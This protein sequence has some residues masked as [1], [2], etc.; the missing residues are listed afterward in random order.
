MLGATQTVNMITSSKQNYGRVEVAVLNVDL[1]PNMIDTVVIGD[2][3]FSLPIH[4]EGRVENE[5]LE[6]QM[7]LDEGAGD[8]ANGFDKP[9]NSGDKSP[10]GTQKLDKPEGSGSKKDTSSRGKQGNGSSK[11]RSSAPIDSDAVDVNVFTP[12][13]HVKLKPGNSSLN[14]NQDISVQVTSNQE[15]FFC[16]GNIFGYKGSRH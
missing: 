11:E 7:D 5:E 12:E 10:Q 8:P 15:H 14:F 9:S 6:V 16:S 2:R 4:V 1:I 3:L 13:H